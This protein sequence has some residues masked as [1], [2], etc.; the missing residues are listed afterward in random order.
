[1]LQKRILDEQEKD[2]EKPTFVV[3]SNAK[4][5]ITFDTA[6]HSATGV[7]RVR[8][9]ICGVFGAVCARSLMHALCLGVLTR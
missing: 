9:W 6:E 8:G 2:K 1:M 7:P 5:R 3:A 4:G